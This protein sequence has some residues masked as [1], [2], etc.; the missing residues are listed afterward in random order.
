MAADGGLLLWPVTGGWPADRS[1]GSGR[2][3]APDSYGARAA[4]QV[5]R[6]GGNAVDAAVATGFALAVTYP[7]AGNIGGGGFMTLYVN[8]K[9]Y[10]LDYRETA[11]AAASADMYLDADGQADPR[12][13]PGRQSRRRR[14]RHGARAGR[15][16]PS[17]RQAELAAG[18][19]PGDRAAPA[20][21]FVVPPG[22]IDRTRRVAAPT[23]PQH[24][25]RR[26]GQGHDRRASASASRELADDA[27][28]GSPRAAPRSSTRAGPPI[29]IVAQ[30]A[31]GPVKGLITQADLAAYKAVWRDAD[32]RRLARLRR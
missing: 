15:G 1:L 11:P 25:L 26:L 31:R 12:P 13:Q 8:G 5:L 27:A 3:A 4:R 16:A 9:P 24:Q 19:G 29:C 14:A 2:C 6:E 21:G 7:E 22:L 32:R 18:P 17:L 28:S 10:F 23:S 20:T 30:M